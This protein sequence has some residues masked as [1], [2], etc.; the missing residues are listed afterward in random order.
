M[1]ISV[2]A[3][4]IMFGLVFFLTA[5]CPKAKNPRADI[6]AQLTL[7]TLSI[8]DILAKPNWEPVKVRMAS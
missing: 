8:L 3:G 7:L 5:N 2:R 6:L 4:Q 1:L